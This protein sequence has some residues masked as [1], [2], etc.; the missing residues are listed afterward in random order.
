[1]ISYLLFED[2]E[3][4]NN[5]TDEQ[6]EGEESSKYN[7]TNKVEIPEKSRLRITLLSNLQ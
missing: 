4:V 1:M 5:D 6:V 7:K 3:I 2:I